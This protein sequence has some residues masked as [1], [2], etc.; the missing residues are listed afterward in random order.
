MQSTP[1]RVGAATAGHGPNM[2]ARTDDAVSRRERGSK[3]CQPRGSVRPTNDWPRANAADGWEEQRLLCQCRGGPAQTGDLPEEACLI[4]DR[5][6]PVPLRCG[7]D[8][9]RRVEE[10]LELLASYS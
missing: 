4:V 5:L 3:I 1:V 6:Q 2:P 9:V 7:D 8:L 10:D